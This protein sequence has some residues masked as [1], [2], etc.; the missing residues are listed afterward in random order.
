LLSSSSSLSAASAAASS[1][2]ASSS[3]LSLSLG[4]VLPPLPPTLATAATSPTTGTTLP[5]TNSTSVVASYISAQ[6][7]TEKWPQQVKM[8]TTTT[9]TTTRL[10]CF[11]IICFLHLIC[12]HT[13][14]FYFEL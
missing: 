1:A 4:T 14:G 10:D 3:S 11:L 7:R 6:F 9:T 5:M 8:A 2:A 12:L 13:Y